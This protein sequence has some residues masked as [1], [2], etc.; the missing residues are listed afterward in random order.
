MI[1]SPFEIVLYSNPYPGSR[2]EYILLRNTLLQQDELFIKI[3]GEWQKFREAFLKE[4]LER[5]G[6]LQCVYCHRDNLEV[7]EF[8]LGYMNKNV[9]NENLA[10]IDHK[11]ALAKGGDR[12]DGD[13][14]LVACKHCNTRKGTK[15]FDEFIESMKQAREQNDRQ[16]RMA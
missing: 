4:I 13:N 12:F 11:L 3:I 6:H 2:A 16:R 8:D 15:N 1:S 9:Y 14:L 7:G 5:K 10:T